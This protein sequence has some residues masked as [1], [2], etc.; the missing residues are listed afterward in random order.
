VSTHAG[1]SAAPTS[2]R[3]DIRRLPWTS[4]LAADYAYAPTTLLPFFAGDVRRADDWRQAI[5]RAQDQP[6]DRTALVSLLQAQQ[7]RRGAPASASDAAT[8]LRDPRSVVVA[9]GQQ[10]GLFGG[11]LYTVLKA[12]S[13]LALADEV[14]RAHGVPAAAVFWVDA[15]DH[16]WAEVNACPVWD[17]EGRVRTI[18]LEGLAP[19]AGTPAA[20]VRLDASVEAAREALRSTLPPTEF[21]EQVLDDLRRAYAPGIGVADACARWLEHLLGPRGLVVFDASDPAA[22]PMAAGVFS[23]ELAHAGESGRLAAD[24]G[25]HLQALG[26]HAQVT[27]QADAVSLFRCGDTRVPLRRA[28]GSLVAGT[29]ARAVDAWLREVRERPEGFSPNVLLRPLVQDAIFPTVAYVAGPSELAYF[30]QLRGVYE[31][32]GVPMPLVYPRGSATLVDS[33]ATRFLAR[34]DV[35]FAS[36]Q[37]QDESA[38]NAL[39]AAALP[40]SVDYAAQQAARTVDAHM[41]ALAAEVVAV[42]P[43]LEGATRSAQGRMQDDLRKLQAKILQAAKRKDETLR[44]QFTHAQ[45]QAFPAG[46]PQERAVSTVALLNRYGPTLV[47]R[48]A[49]EVGLDLG[50]HTLLTP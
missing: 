27:V 30:A 34:G 29:D 5:T 19:A 42:D 2:S 37:P 25:R 33:N 15:E 22:K 32:F 45:A 14:R 44:R 46:T 36:L 21:T 48:L 11:P 28:N 38:L 50:T 9:T 18:A 4:R 47:D 13:A 49:A 16:D 31:A 12:L 10:A 8:A 26:Y 40:A 6:H 23:W 41:A 17:A 20:R 35:D 3:L 7:R 24:A 43:T 1:A 39:L